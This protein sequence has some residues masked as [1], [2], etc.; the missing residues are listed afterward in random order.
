MCLVSLKV[1]GGSSHPLPQDFKKVINYHVWNF[2][3]NF[4][5]DFS[6][7]TMDSPFLFKFLFKSFWDAVDY[8]LLYTVMSIISPL[9]NEWWLAVLRDAALLLAYF[10][11]CRVLVP[12]LGIKPMP[13]T[14]AVWSRITSGPPRK[15][16]IPLFLKIAL[17][18]Y[19]TCSTSI[20]W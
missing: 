14:V 16:R 18:D 11:A 5:H 3:N 20:T 13:P 2:H 12:R 19:F 1:I 4:A 7:W 8:K 10:L 17:Y 6:R 15:S 9:F